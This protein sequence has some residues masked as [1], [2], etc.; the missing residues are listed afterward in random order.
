MGQSMAEKPP[1]VR[2]RKHQELEEVPV[3]ELEEV[4]VE[5]LEEVPVEELGEVARKALEEEL[6]Q[7][8]QGAEALAAAVVAATAAEVEEVL[9][10][11]LLRALQKTPIKARSV[12]MMMTMVMMTP[13]TIQVTGSSRIPHQERAHARRGANRVVARLAEVANSPE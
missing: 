7:A 1:R 12:A 11:T 2:N 4:P 6:D 9:Q 10:E 3:E 5:E 13:R 8:D